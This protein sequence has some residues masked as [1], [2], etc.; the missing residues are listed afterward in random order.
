M[1]GFIG[2]DPKDVIIEDLKRTVGSLERTLRAAGS[3][4]PQP[5]HNARDHQ[6]ATEF[7]KMANA[8]RASLDFAESLK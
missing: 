5:Y 7:I 4:D 2:V 8:A 3:F 6:L 1:I